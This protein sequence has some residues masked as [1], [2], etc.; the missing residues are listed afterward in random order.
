MFRQLTVRILT[1][2]ARGVLRKYAPTVVAVTGSVGKTLTKEAIARVLVGSFSV[3]K[4]GANLNSEFGVPL[5]ILGARDAPHTVREWLFAIRRGFGVRFGRPHY[6]ALLVL[7]FA[8]DRPGDI[9]HLAALA[10]PRV[11]VVTAVGATHLERLGTVEQVAREKAALIR[12]LPDDGFALLSADDALVL[13]MRE[14]TSATV[15]TFGLSKHAEIRA[16]KV[17]LALTPRTLDAVQAAEPASVTGVVVVERQRHQL[18]LPGFAAPYQAMSAL[19]A[20]GVGRAFGI[21][22]PAMLER[23]TTL[24]PLKGRMRLL[25]GIN[26]AAILDDSYNASP[27]AVTAALEVLRAFPKAKRRI[28]VLGEMAELGASAQAAHQEMGRLAAQAADVLIAVGEA[29]KPY[30]DGALEAKMKGEAIL[31]F[32]SP[33]EAGEWLRE[34][35]QQTDVVLVKGSQAAR[36]EKAVA[37]ALLEPDRAEEFLV[38]QSAYWERQ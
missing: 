2:L 12:G 34:H 19:A 29:A 10:R 7:E 13:K 5:A 23:L 31:T 8:A 37:A 18:V 11:G 35:L 20:I 3:W 22:L 1:W 14:E 21:E 9:A 27:K 28:A 25:P 33:D 17:R 36:M 4:S 6:P 30:V 38:R 15:A 24:R 32:G 16:D 26:H